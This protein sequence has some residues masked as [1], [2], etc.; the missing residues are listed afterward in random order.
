MHMDDLQIKVLSRG[1]ENQVAIWLLGGEEV[2]CPALAGSVLQVSGMDWNR[3]FSPWPAPAIRKNEEG[4]SGGGKAFLQ[5]LESEVLPQSFD[6]LG[7]EPQKKYLAG[8]SL[9][10][11]FSLFSLTQT[12]T[13]DGCACMSGS[14][15][16][17]GFAEQFLQSGFA[18]RPSYVY[19]S[20]GIQEG[21]TR[22]PVMASIDSCTEEV[23]T[24]FR[25][26]GIP[27]QFQWWPGGHFHQ[28]PERIAHGLTALI[29]AEKIDNKTKSA[30]T[31]S[32]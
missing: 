3:D 21:K 7:F 15:W 11:L 28:I 32:N 23:C 2:A 17:P 10:G 6:L 31:T 4:F 20:L 25:T 24:Y 16:Y 8:Y 29:D 12:K 13:F 5:R 27:Y 19:L 30:Y 14:L 22:N 1:M 9:A 26:E 18:G